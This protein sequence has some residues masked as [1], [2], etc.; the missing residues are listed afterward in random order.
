MSREIITIDGPSG[1]GKSTIS[2]AVAARLGF[3]YLDTGAMYRAVGYYAIQEGVDPSDEKSLERL[4]TDMELELYPGSKDTRIF[5]NKQEISLAIRTAE[6]G[7]AA[8]RVSALPTVRDRLTGIQQKIGRKGKIVAE[9]RDTGTVVFPE[10]RYKFYLD[11]SPEERARRRTI[12]LREQG[13]EADEQVI[14]Q[15]LKERD[16]ADSSRARAP[17]CKAV[18]AVVIDSSNLTIDEVIELIIG[19]VKEPV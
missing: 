15:Q 3:T 5:L 16:K 14:L 11:A 9:G 10:A 19:Q 13:C 7:L 18:D 2:R 6:M 12:Q 17:L 1:S 8:S 4:L